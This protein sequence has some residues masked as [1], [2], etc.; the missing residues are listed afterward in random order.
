MHWCYVTIGACFVIATIIRVIIKLLTKNEVI[1][2]H[3]DEFLGNLVSSVFVMELGVMSNMYG[4]KSFYFMASFLLHLIIKHIF[5]MNVKAYGHIFTFVDM[6]Y[7]NQRKVKFSFLLFV[8]IM[9]VQALGVLCGQWIS[10]YM[11]TF[12]DHVHVYSGQEVCLTNL[13]ASYTWYHALLLEAFGVFT[14]TSIDFVTPYKLK[15]VI[16]S[17]ITLS[18][19]QMFGYAS[20][21]WM[22]PVFATMFT[23]RCK[24]HRSDLEHLLVYWLGPI[25]GFALSWEMKYV[26]QSVQSTSE[27]KVQ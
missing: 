15:P 14:A 23:F 11:W 24:G 18:L 2:S 17:C 7:T 20:G 27:K 21:L 5:F 1:M 19:L 4:S 16:R 6:Y 22:H 10:K 26:I 3:V 25:I 12:E 8:S 9:V 13:A